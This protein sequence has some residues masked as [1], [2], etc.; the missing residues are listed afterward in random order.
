MLAASTTKGAAMCWKCDNPDGT[1]EQYLDHLRA[2]IQDHGWAVQYVESDKRPL[3]YTVGLH[4]RGLPELLMTGLPA[5]VSC[6]VLNSIAHMIVDD[7]VELAPAMHIDYEDRFLIE[8]AQV[9]H[10]D[11]HM[12]FAVELFGRDFP[13]LQLV[14]ADERGCFP[15]APGWGHGRRRQPVLG[16]RAKWPN[17]AA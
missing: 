13:A 3:A 16:R 15:W 10:P 6:R 12:R 14:W 8:V 17:S 5:N 1:T 2:T 9:E 4:S 11:I 7:G